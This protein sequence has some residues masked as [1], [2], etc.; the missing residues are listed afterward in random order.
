MH[1]MGT[2]IYCVL[3]VVYGDAVLILVL[4]MVLLMRSFKLSFS[5]LTLLLAYNF[6]VLCVVHRLYEDHNDLLWELFLVVCVEGC[7]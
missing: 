3:V 5:H 4:K 7:D 1:R 6:S 2:Y